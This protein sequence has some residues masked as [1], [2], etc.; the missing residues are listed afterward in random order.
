MLPCRASGSGR[1]PPAD[2]QRLE[3]ACVPEGQWEYVANEES[4]PVPPCPKL[5][6]PLFTL[7]KWVRQSMEGPAGKP[8]RSPWSLLP[9]HII[10]SQE[11][12][13]QKPPGGSASPPHQRGNA[14]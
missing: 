3:W 11:T 6:V 7:L 4:W 10:H 2:Q 5:S 14:V 8:N 13:A 12:R 1:S 9:L